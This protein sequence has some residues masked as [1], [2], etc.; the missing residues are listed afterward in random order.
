MKNIVLFLAVILFIFPISFTSFA[1]DKVVVI[2]LNS[3]RAN[4]TGWIYIN[5]SSPSLSQGAVFI[6]Q[7]GHYAGIDLPV[8]DSPGFQFGFTIPHDFKKGSD[9]T[10]HLL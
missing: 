6:T 4:T 8:T 7:V 9:L 2:P 5:P 3:S 10:L 1:A